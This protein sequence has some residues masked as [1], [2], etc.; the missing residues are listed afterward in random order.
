M[1]YYIIIIGSLCFALILM[2]SNGKIIFTANKNKYIMC[3]LVVCWAISAFRSVEVGADTMNYARIF[4]ILCNSTWRD[5]FSS[6][7][8]QGTEIGFNVMAKAVGTCGGDYYV[9]QLLIC[10]LF[11]FGFYPFISKNCLNSVLAMTV[12][13]GSGLYLYSFNISRQMVAV[14]FVANAWDCLSEK[15][16]KKFVILLFLAC[17]FHSTAVIFLLAFLG[18]YCWKNKLGRMLLIALL[19]TFLIFYMRFFDMVKPLLRKYYNYASYLDNNLEK[20]TAG[21]II[22]FWIIVVVMALL[23]I[24]YCRKEKTQFS[25]IGFFSIVYVV[26]NI[27]GLQINYFYR[28]GYFFMPFLIPL[29][30]NFYYLIKRKYMAKAYMLS[31]I[32]CLNIYFILSI[33]ASQYKYSSFLF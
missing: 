5:I 11:C 17:V 3:S 18:Y 6:F 22:Y 24:Y 28:I 10:A 26:C 15:R 32:M 19:V 23:T 25:I 29:F 33:N 2:F 1:A 20:Q 21:M 31:A 27:V 4:R 9:F 8:Y 14:M 7:K 13:Y 30:D 16:N 12:F